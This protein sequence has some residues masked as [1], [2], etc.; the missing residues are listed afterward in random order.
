[1]FVTDVVLGHLDRAHCSL[2]MST[3]MS[4]NAPECIISRRLLALEVSRPLT[5]PR[6][7]SRPHFVRTVFLLVGSGIGSHLQANH[8]PAWMG[9][10]IFCTHTHAQECRCVRVCVCVCIVFHTLIDID[11]YIYMSMCVC[12]I[13][14][15]VSWRTHAR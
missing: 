6:P 7:E 11:I 3:P 5:R 13:C 15:C 9:L 12:C 8:A 1:M 2:N 14:V 10:Y 4:L